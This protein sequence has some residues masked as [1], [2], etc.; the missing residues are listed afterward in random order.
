MLLLPSVLPGVIR[1]HS[2]VPLVTVAVLLLL[3][4]SVHLLHL[5]CVRVYHVIVSA[6]SESCL[7]VVVVV[8]VLLLHVVIVHCVHGEHAWVVRVRVVRLVAS[9]EGAGVASSP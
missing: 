2:A 4:A 5:A 3:P 8:L 9:V 7:V 1:A 6:V